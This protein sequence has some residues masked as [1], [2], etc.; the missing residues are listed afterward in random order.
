MEKFFLSQAMEALKRKNS[1]IIFQVQVTKIKLQDAWSQTKK[2]A[3]CKRDGYPAS[4]RE[5]TDPVRAMACNI[6][7]NDS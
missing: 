6:I 1:N 5:V 7:R 2:V 3:S 4:W